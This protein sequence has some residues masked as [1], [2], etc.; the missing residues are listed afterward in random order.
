MRNFYYI[1]IICCSFI[2]A[3]NSVD[4]NFPHEEVLDE[5]LMPLQGITNPLGWR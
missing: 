5:K 2:L 1:L 3:C 4:P